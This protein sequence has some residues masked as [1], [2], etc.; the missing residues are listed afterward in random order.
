MAAELNFSSKPMV[1][2][3]A[4][5]AASASRGETFPTSHFYPTAG[6]IFEAQKD[7]GLIAVITLFE[8]RPEDRPPKQNS[9]GSSMGHSPMR[10]PA[11]PEAD[12]LYRSPP[13]AEPDQLR[14]DAGLP[15]LEDIQRRLSLTEAIEIPR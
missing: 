6:C 5:A 1:H 14:T 13:L 7:S 15:D 3:Q 4:K 10:A 12:N 2:K 8:P 9:S 11:L